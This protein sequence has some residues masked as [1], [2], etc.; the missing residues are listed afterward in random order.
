[1]KELFIAARSFILSMSST[2]CWGRKLH[3]THYSVIQ[4]VP[5][6]LGWHKRPPHLWRFPEWPPDPGTAV[7]SLGDTFT[8][9]HSSHGVFWQRPGLHRDTCGRDHTGIS[10]LASEWLCRL[11]PILP[12]SL[13]LTHFSRSHLR[14][15]MWHTCNSIPHVCQRK[16][17]L[18]IVF[19]L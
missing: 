2:G 3:N 19:L 13:P 16:W 12:P 7:Q 11:H 17:K 6:Y 15:M 9:A 10:A 14:G 8:G 1:M 4:W 5:E 18:L